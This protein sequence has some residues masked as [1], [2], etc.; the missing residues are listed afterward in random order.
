M[1]G[2]LTKR[3]IYRIL[4]ILLVGQTFIW[5]WS[6]LKQKASLEDRLNEVVSLGG[7]IVARTAATS[8]LSYDYT[9]LEQVLDD[10][11]RNPEILYVE[12]LDHT[13]K[14]LIYK[15]EEILQGRYRTA[16]FPVMAG[17]EA[18]GKVR[19]KYSIEGVRKD[20]LFH[21]VT[22]MILQAVV[23]LGL[24]FLISIFFRR[25]IGSRIEAMSADIE[26]VTLGDL[27]VRLEDIDQTELGTIGRGINFLVERLKGSVTK[28]KGIVTNVAT[29]ISQLNLTFKNVI[30]GVKNQ[31]NAAEEVSQ[32]VRRAMESQK[33][34]LR[35]TEKL[36]SLS[37]DNVSALLELKATSDEIASATDSLQKNINDTYSTTSELSQSSR[38]VSTLSSDVSSAIQQASASVDEINASVKEIER[39]ARD[40][41]E[42]SGKTTGI[43]SEKG[44][45]SIVDTTESME[46]IEGSINELRKSIER[47]GG[48]SK[49]IEK[50]LS[51]VKDITEQTGLL[52]LNAQILAVQAGEYGKSFSVVADEMKTL[53]DRTASST[54]EIASIVK[55]LKN[56][57]K[58]VVVGAGE[59]VKMVGRGSESVMKTAE[60]LREI[61]YSSQQSSDMAENIK[62]ATSEQA[63]GIQLIATAI[64]HIK[65]MILEVNRATEEQDKGISYLLES[66]ASIK[67]SM[68]ITRKSTEEQARSTRFITDNIELANQMTA[69]IS[70]ASSEQQK[71][72]ESILQLLDSV[73]TVGRETVRD[74]KEVSLFISALQDE[75][76]ALRKEMAQFR[77]EEERR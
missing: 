25:D 65:L 60:A 4:L 56:E 57:I 28:L 52:S 17:Q 20:I 63:K 32:S 7:G 8:I 6:F 27:S 58:D 74:V 73:L 26:Q 13:G 29:A 62:R 21:L 18:I 40:S 43:I 68:D 71:V 34:I 19:I 35:N 75:V 67:E 10:I 33:Q 24:V 53:S 44:M 47:L 2:S 11:S 70:E 59:T 54:R 55:S 39:I 45:L 69:E 3:F 37:N 5:G 38:E 49:D 76:E 48:M 64:E 9:Y 23:L 16:M 31:Q 12:V 66:I 46:S 42:L 22:T 36:L 41:A 51:V 1:A 14:R 61:L 15:G 72:N 50:I 30:T 77:T